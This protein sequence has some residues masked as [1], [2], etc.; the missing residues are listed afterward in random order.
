MPKLAHKPPSYRR[1]R[2]SG[3]ALVCI[4]GKRIYLGKWNT[5]ASR[6]RYHQLVGEWI[7][8][9]KQ[10]PKPAEDHDATI[11]E[12]IVRFW[13]FAKGYYRKNGMPTKELPCVREAMRPLREQYGRTPAHNFGPLAAKAVRQSMIDQGWARTTVNSRMIRIKR[14]FKWAAANELVPAEVYHGLQAV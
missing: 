13:R 8:N 10:T 3:R 11:T 2:P 5:A 9:D 4:D 1:H 7:A 14:M 12:L 6:K